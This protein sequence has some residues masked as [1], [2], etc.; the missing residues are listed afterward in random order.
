MDA[1]AVESLRVTDWVAEY[2]PAAGLKLGVAACGPDCVVGVKVQVSIFW[3][4]V[5]P[6]VPP[7]NPTYAVLPPTTCGML[8]DQ[9]FVNVALVTP[10][11]MVIVSV[12]PSYTMCTL[13]VSP[14]RR[15]IPEFVISTA[16]VVGE[17]P[18]V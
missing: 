11:V 8:T 12:V 3:L 13:N 16:G 2:V 18:F 9:L 14:L 4:E 1:P 17:A 15:L 10:S 5:C 7:V 6:P